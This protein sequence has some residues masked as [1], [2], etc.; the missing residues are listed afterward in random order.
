MRP[1]RCHCG[2]GAETQT[3]LWVAWP[4]CDPHQGHQQLTSLSGAGVEL[5][6]PLGSPIA[7]GQITFTCPQLVPVSVGKMEV[8]ATCFVKGVPSFQAAG[9]WVLL[10]LLLG[11]WDVQ[12]LGSH[13]LSLPWM[14]LGHSIP[15]ECFGAPAAPGGKQCWGSCSRLERQLCPAQKFWAFPEQLD[16]HLFGKT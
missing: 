14:G 2:K 15:R 5:L 11:T 7:G 9:P 1:S 6:A 16:S 13:L 4:G 12:S 10:K 3:Q 8:I